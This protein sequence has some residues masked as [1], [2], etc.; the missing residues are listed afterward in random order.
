VAV[1]FGDILRWRSYQGRVL[2]AYQCGIRRFLAVWHR[3]AG[4]DLTFFALTVLAMLERPGNYFHVF[5]KL[6]QARKDFW[7]AIDSDGRPYLDRF[8]KALVIGEPN[9]TEMLVKLRLPATA[10][11]EA[12]HATWQLVGADDEEAVERLRGANP[13]GLVFSEAA[14]IDPVVWRTLFPVLAENGGWAAWIS[15]FKGENHFWKMYQ[16]YRS[17]PAWCVDLQ[18]VR[19]TKRDA[20]GERGEPVITEA[21]IEELR[22]A[23]PD[24]GGM[25]EE[26]IQQEFYCSPTVANVGAYY[27]AALRA[28]TEAGRITAVPYDPNLLVKTA[29]D[30]GLGRNNAIWFYQT[31][32]G[33][34]VRVIDYHEGQ[35]GDALPQHAHAVK[36]QRR[37]TYSHHTAPHDAA[38]P[39]IGS[40][41]SRIEVARTLGI[42]FRLA[43]RLLARNG[44]GEVQQG[45]DATLRLFPRLWFDAERC[46][47]GLEH[48][49]AYVRRQVAPGTFEDEPDPAC[50]P[51]SHAADA[52]RYLAV[53]LQEGNDQAA[54]PRVRSAF[55]VYDH[56]REPA[57]AGRRVRAAFNAFGDAA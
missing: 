52:L 53:D 28:A 1:D 4:K 33:G 18:T 44:K 7:R 6:T 5:P 45:I 20:A 30:L 34:N 26:E 2:G 27:G 56:E 16:Q 41:K 31:D 36:E 15:T 40:G 42:R 35:D 8:P 24:A 54:P 11:G 17:D 29:W 39:D 37:Y 49:K 32:R 19:D 3:R 21:A 55:D 9:E 22:K 47:I 14:L 50:K 43:R 12:R 48:L 13:V 46:K 23:P 51:H 25:S 10:A 57:F 38:T